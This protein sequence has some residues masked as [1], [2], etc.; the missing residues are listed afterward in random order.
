L[1]QQAML[2]E[3]ETAAARLA[4]KVSY[5]SL[6]SS[7]GTGGLCRVRGEYRVIIDKRTQVS[8]RVAALAQA[9]SQVP[10]LSPELA[11][12]PELS[13]PVRHLIR[14]Y[15]ALRRAS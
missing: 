13:A 14:H 7:V 4:V 8:E 3:L 15:A 5:E 1:N 10:D 11:V 6:A 9:L 12:A 2:D